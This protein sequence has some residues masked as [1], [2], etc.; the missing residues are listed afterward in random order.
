MAEHGFSALV[1]VRRGAT[2][3]TLLFDTGMSP[4]AMVTNAER[5]GIDL[6]GSR[7]W[8]SATAT[9]TTPAA[10]PGWPGSGEPGRCRWWSTR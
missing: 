3:T 10:W 2:T 6:S 1:S 7:R 4:D 8:S 9:S 5:L